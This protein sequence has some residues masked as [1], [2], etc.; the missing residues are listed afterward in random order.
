VVLGLLLTGRTLS[1]PA[2]VGLIMLVGIVVSNAIIFVD[3]LK[4]LLESGMEREAAILEAGQVRLRPILMTAFS[5]ILAMF[6]LSLGL[7][8]GGEAQAPLATVVIGGLLISTLVTL[9]LVPVVYTIFDDW[10]KKLG[11]RFS[12]NKEISA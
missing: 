6:P 12:S 11:K 5:T 1:V 4:Q 2:F 9:V 7:G 3:Y 10:G 8:E